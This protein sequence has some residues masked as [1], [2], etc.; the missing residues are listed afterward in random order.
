ML[1]EQENRIQ[2]VKAQLWSLTLKDLFFKYL[3]F[4]PWF[5]FFIIIS[6]TAGYLYIRYSTPIYSTSGLLLL[7]T[8]KQNRQEDKYE[9]I[10]YTSRIQDLQNEIEILRS[11]A[12][13]SRVIQK[14][15]LNF[16]FFTKGRIKTQ[17]S[18]KQIP[19]TLIVENLKDSSISFSFKILFFGKNKF[20]LNKDGILYSLNKSFQNEFGTFRI[21]STDSNLIK[22]EYY[23]RY[24][25]VWM[26]AAD[27]ASRLKV[28]PKSPGSSLLIISMEHSNPHLAADLVNY[29]MEEYAEFS[30]EQKK[31]T[32]DTSLVFIENRLKQ[33]GKELDSV[34]NILLDYMIKNKIYDLEQ[35][36]LNYF[37]K[38]TQLDNSKMNQLLQLNTA[39]FIE[40]YLRDK[41]NSYSTVLVPSSLGLTDATLNSLVSHYNLLQMERQKLIDGNVPASNPVIVNLNNQ[42]EELRI[43]L[44]E[45]LAN[46]QNSLKKTIKSLQKSNEE[47]QNI[48]SNIPSKE[49]EYLEIKQQVENKQILYNL[50]MQKREETALSRAASLEN[51]QIIEKATPPAQPIK[52]RKS[53]VYFV[54]LVFGLVIPFL[55]LFVKEVFNDKVNTRYD[56]ENIT[57]APILGEVGHSLSKD[58]LV[59]SKNSRKVISEQFRIIRSNLQFILVK[60]SPATILVTSSL[61]GEGKTFTSINMGAVLALTGKKTIILEFD[62]RKPK[63]LSSL[64]FKK[65]KGIVNFLVGKE[66]EIASLIYNVPQIENL[67]IL[68]S[69]PTPPNPGELLL[70]EKVAVL[71]NWLKQEFEIIIIDTA[72]VGLVSDAQTLAKFADCTLYVVRHNHTLK[73]LVTFIDDFY[74]KNKLPSVSIVINDVKDS[75]GYGYYGYGYY[76]YG[77]HGYGY[78]YGEYFDIEK[79]K[80]KNSIKKLFGFLKSYRNSS[81]N[82]NT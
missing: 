19:F 65:G 80:E 41:K 9:E 69:G 8:E 52:P 21:V 45:I 36:S 34:K 79:Q 7:K 22:G 13:F 59:V 17:N 18:Y 16:E 64:N 30:R 4:L 43:N 23:I 2:E 49:K 55:Y 5:V 1:P 46:I 76:G 75:I 12:L 42:I 60:K 74:K 51:S 81:S 24:R 29:L 73:K 15:R 54:T 32:A 33:Y 67:Y 28:K 20:R 3:R 62:I 44:L 63:L 39:E 70:S 82:N 35:Q 40:N 38:I 37:E 31:R 6:L 57:Q 26:K 61:S 72:P 58:V 50:L 27:Y 77:R 11:K 68:G 71:F 56:I 53:L 78:G 47:T 66:N 14:N 48:L 10:F 25:P